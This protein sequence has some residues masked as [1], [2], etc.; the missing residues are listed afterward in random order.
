V[1]ELWRNRMRVEVLVQG[2]DTRNYEPVEVS[3]IA[4]K[5]YIDTKRGVTSL[6]VRTDKGLVSVGGWGAYI[7]DIQANFIHVRGVP[8]RG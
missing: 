6:Y 8:R 2:V 7:E 5:V 1:R 4:R 3:G